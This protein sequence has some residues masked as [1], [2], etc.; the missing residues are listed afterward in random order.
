MYNSKDK[1]LDSVKRN[2]EAYNNALDDESS[3][4]KI[5][6]NRTK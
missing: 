3:K 6:D 1:I 5:T 2:L 4:V